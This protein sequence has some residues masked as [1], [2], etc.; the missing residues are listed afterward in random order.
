MLNTT[1]SND[2][3]AWA[4]LAAGY[5]EAEAAAFRSLQGNETVRMAHL[6]R[7]S[8]VLAVELDPSG[9]RKFMILNGIMMHYSGDPIA[10]YGNSSTMGH[11]I[12]VDTDLAQGFTSLLWKSRADAQGY[13]QSLTDEA[14]WTRPNGDP[15]QPEDIQLATP[16]PSST[17]SA[18]V[19]TMP[20]AL[21][22]RPEV[23][24][25]IHG[26]RVDQGLTQDE[27]LN[28]PE[29]ADFADALHWLETNNHVSLGPNSSFLKWD[30]IDTTAWAPVQV[31]LAI[32]PVA[33]A[34][35]ILSNAPEYHDYMVHH[36]STFQKAIRPSPT[37]PAVPPTAHPAVAVHPIPTLAPT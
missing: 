29:V 27:R 33:A 5:T 3:N 37:I 35:G 28:F 18:V 31:H 11:P 22:L 34:N 1:A 2:T 8:R 19:V 6:C 24:G 14:D 20:K 9:T 4:S 15:I 26:R 21:F 17:D 7:A 10:S 25:D 30:G 16:R 12:R 32:S 23:P 13:L 36:K